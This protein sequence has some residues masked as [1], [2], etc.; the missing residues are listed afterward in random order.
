M[1]IVSVQEIQ[2]AL[3][4]L[5]ELLAEEGELVITQH[6]KPL[7]RIVPLRPDRRMPSHAA[8]RSQMPHL[9]RD[10]ATVVR[11]DRE[12]VQR[13]LQGLNEV[14]ADEVVDDDEVWDEVDQIIGRADSTHKDSLE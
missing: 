3:E 4:R 1:K 10:S 11:E 12:V 2:G 6:G 7:A 14:A 8:L 5:D 13:V 9:I